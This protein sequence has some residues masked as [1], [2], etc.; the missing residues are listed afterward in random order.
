MRPLLLFTLLIYLGFYCHAQ[1]DFRFAD[2]T[3]QWNVSVYVD[4]THSYSTKNYTVVG[5]TFWNGNQYQ[6]IGQIPGDR[7]LLRK[8]S[9]N[10]F[11]TPLPDNTNDE[12]LLYDFGA[13]KGD[14]IAFV[15]LVIG[16]N[17]H[18]ATA[19]VDSVDT[20][21]WHGLRRRLIF[22]PAYQGWTSEIW[23]EGLGALNADPIANSSLTM[24]PGAPD[25]AYNLLCF[26]ENGQLVYQDANSNSCNTAVQDLEE[27]RVDIY[28][29]PAE[30]VVSFQLP[31]FFEDQ[32][33]L[34]QISTPEGQ[35]I[36]NTPFHTSLLK[37]PTTTFA[38]GMYFYSIISKGQKAASGKIILE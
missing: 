13:N 11:Y 26:H 23:V 36:L 10:R 14:T 21:N 34:L 24:Q 28:P 4:Y 6:V 31:D 25:I 3:A 19:I 27:V 15:R 5:D 17:H 12:G 20:V 8:D 38:R 30:D 37:I 16:Y 32:Q 1:T 9:L 33:T 29:N 35:S 22:K 2:S 18:N 7:I